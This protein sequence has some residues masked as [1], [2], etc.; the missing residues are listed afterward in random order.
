MGGTVPTVMRHD[1]EI[2][3]DSRYHGPQPA[4]VTGGGPN[5]N[6]APRNAARPGP[7]RVPVMMVRGG[8]SAG[9]ARPSIDARAEFR[10]PVLL[11][12]RLPAWHPRQAR[13]QAHLWLD[14]LGLPQQCP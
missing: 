10:E 12:C 5:P 7:A 8:G 9:P 14:R 11:R 4:A 1:G 13:A 6:G 3:I 2:S